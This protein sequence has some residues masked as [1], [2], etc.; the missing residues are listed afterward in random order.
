MIGQLDLEMVGGFFPQANTG[1]ENL[2]QLISSY[3]AAH[4]GREEAIQEI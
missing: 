4:K 2:Q 1:W 3:L